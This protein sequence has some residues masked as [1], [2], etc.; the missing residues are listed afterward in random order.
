MEKEHT[1]DNYNKIKDSYNR[2]HEYL[3]ISLTDRC[4]M[5]CSYCYAGHSRP[6]IMSRDVIHRSIDL[7]AER[8]RLF[9]G[10][11]FF[12][13][14]PLLA[15]DEIVDGTHYTLDTARKRGLIPSFSISTNATLLEEEH[16]DFFEEHDISLGISIDG[17]PE[18]QRFG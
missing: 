14:E 9:L 11:R 6:E 12:G 15:W 18:I 1:A 7:V 5:R 17:S 13:G 16:L 3:R 4:N 8:S 2:V 10:V